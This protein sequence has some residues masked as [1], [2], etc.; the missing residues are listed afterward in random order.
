MT[1]ATECNRLM[2]SGIVFGKPK[3]PEEPKEFD[4]FKKDKCGHYINNVYPMH[5]PNEWRYWNQ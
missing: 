1:V 5:I 3:E 4:P 2:K